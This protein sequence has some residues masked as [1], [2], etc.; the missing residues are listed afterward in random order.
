MVAGLAPDMSRR[1]EACGLLFRLCRQAL[2][3]KVADVG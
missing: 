3:E 1:F 2:K